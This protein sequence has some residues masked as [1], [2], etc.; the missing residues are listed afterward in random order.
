MNYRNCGGRVFAVLLQNMTL[1]GRGAFYVRLK[2]N[3]K[4]PGRSRRDDAGMSNETRKSKPCAESL[5]FPGEG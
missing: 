1:L 4:V 3:R 2:G 5:R